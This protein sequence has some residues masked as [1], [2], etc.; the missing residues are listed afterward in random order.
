M[1]RPGAAVRA[2]GIT[3]RQA[4]SGGWVVWRG[5]QELGSIEYS[6]QSKKWVLYSKGNLFD[7]FDKAYDAKEFVRRNWK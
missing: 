3:F 6:K 2:P 7:R 4:K 5:E 1:K